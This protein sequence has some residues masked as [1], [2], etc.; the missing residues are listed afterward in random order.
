M[1]SLRYAVVGV[2]AVGG[3]YGARLQH[4]GREVHFLARSEHAELRARGL[5]VESRDGNLALGSIQVYRRPEEMPPCDV[6]LVTVPTTGNAGLGAL[7]PGLCRPGTTVVMLQSGLGMEADVAA[8][9]GVEHV[10]GGLGFL[11]ARRLAPGRVQ[12]E[13][14]GSLAL[15]EYACGYVATAPGP[16]LC[17]I[18]EDFTAAGVP[19]E[20]YADLLLARWKKLL[21]NVPF[22]GLSVVLR[23]S[24][25]EI[26]AD[27]SMRRLVQ[28]LM[29]EVVGGAASCGRVVP[30]SY[31]QEL[32]EKAATCRS[33]PS[34]MSLDFAARRPLELDAIYRR[35]LALMARRGVSAQ[36]LETLYRQL[37]FL[38]PGLRRGRHVCDL[39][40][41]QRAA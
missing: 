10:V 12:H 16:R 15:G 32:I 31:A 5:A 40:L 21:W 22:D 23:A 30:R 8:L 20:L 14:G 3:Y 13:E 35:P 33:Q 36:H 6:V 39:P 41:D 27:P 11:C 18:S 2:G 29:E 19:V 26:V 28:E 9:A 34:R 38:D 24:L 4:A 37:R 1:Q 25:D 17:A 7:L